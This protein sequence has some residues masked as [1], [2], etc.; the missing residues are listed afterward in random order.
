MVASRD[1][2]CKRLAGGWITPPWNE[3]SPEW[4][5]LDQRLPL[6]HLARLIAAVVEELDLNTCARRYAG[7]GRRAPPA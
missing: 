2:D 1:A 6:D 5:T 4:I 7:V 3:E